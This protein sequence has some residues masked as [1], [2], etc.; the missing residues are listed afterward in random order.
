MK[1]RTQLLR[2]GQ[3]QRTSGLCEGQSRTQALIAAASFFDQKKNRAEPKARR[4]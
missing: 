2:I 3:Q 1:G 4:R